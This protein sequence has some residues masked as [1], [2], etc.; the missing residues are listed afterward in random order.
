MIRIVLDTNILHQ[1]GL[2]SRNMQ[3]LARL[4]ESGELKVYV[5]E[6]VK[7]EFITKRIQDSVDRLQEAKS[8][9]GE[10]AKKVDRHGEINDTII[11]I[12]VDLDSVGARLANSIA[13][14]FEEWASAS[15]ATILKFEPTSID[16][17]L[18]DY[19]YGR[20]AYRRPKARDDI[21]DAIISSCICALSEKH[22]KTFVAVKDGTLRKHLQTINNI[23]VSDSLSDFFMIADVAAL[24][25]GLDARTKNVE[26]TKAFFASTSFVGRLSEFLSSADELL[27][28]VYVEEDGIEGG[29]NLE[30]EGFGISVNY[31]EANKLHNLSCGDVAYINQGHFSINI[32]FFTFAK[33]HYCGHYSDFSNLPIS[34]LERVEE[35]S[36]NGDGI[37]DLRERREV[38]LIGYVDLFFD[39]DWT[40]DALAIHSHYLS[41]DPPP[42]RIDLNVQSAIIL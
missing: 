1:E 14:D 21:P 29:G 11:K 7:R 32:E 36:M 30:V 16:S 41:S 42:I 39:P 10:V 17:V 34:R 27:S 15:R 13:T 24:V 25:Q 2:S 19:F 23:V 40:A 18:D 37:S 33:I 4:A 20:G 35:V 6:M 38:K 3:L 26:A 28:D 31:A 8:A 5:P 12:H 9:L 22:E